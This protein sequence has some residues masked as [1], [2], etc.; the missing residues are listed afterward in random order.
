MAELLSVK[1]LEIDKMHLENKIQQNSIPD[2][3]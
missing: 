3:P 2:I 1:I